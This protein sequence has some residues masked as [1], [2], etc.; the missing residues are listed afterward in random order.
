MKHHSEINCPFMMAISL[1]FVCVNTP[2]PSFVLNVPI[3]YFHVF[4]MTD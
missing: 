3:S 4:A 2:P 1:E